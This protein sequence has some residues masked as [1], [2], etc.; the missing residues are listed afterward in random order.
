MTSDLTVAAEFA[1]S[2]GVV[3]LTLEL[4]EVTAGGAPTAGTPAAEIDVDN[5]GCLGAASPYQFLA[6]KGQALTLATYSESGT[7]FYSWT[8]P[9]PSYSDDCTFTPSVDT[10]ITA[11]FYSP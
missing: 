11:S 1:P 8:G 3:T 9:C 2:A 5:M 10:A 6:T 7:A 4:A